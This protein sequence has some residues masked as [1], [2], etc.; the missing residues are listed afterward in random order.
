MSLLSEAKFQGKRYFCLF[1][2]CPD[3]ISDALFQIYHMHL[4]DSTVASTLGTTNNVSISR[5]FASMNY[6]NRFRWRSWTLFFLKLKCIPAF[7]RVGHIDKSKGFHELY[8][9]DAGM[10]FEP[11]GVWQPLCGLILLSF[12]P[13]LLI[14]GAQCRYN[15][16]V[17]ACNQL[18]IPS[19]LRVFWEW[20]KFFTQCPIDLN[21]VQ[22]IFQGVDAPPAPPL[23][24]GLLMWISF[25]PICANEDQVSC[26]IGRYIRHKNSTISYEAELFRI[27]AVQK[28]NT[29][30]S[31][32]RASCWIVY[33]LWLLLLCIIL[34]RVR[35]LNN[36]NLC[37][38]AF[39]FT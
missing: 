30:L 38:K 20:P 35:N 16:Y 26:Q 12:F 8:F 7:P 9:T 28:T 1:M 24:T 5:C 13:V 34:S 32:R 18:G 21:Y 25:F 36:G 33:A 27:V 29:L 10:S 14:G 23:V 15:T 19:G 22:N 4:F 3:L 6:I 39:M 37:E 2:K 17:Q 11:L 31:I